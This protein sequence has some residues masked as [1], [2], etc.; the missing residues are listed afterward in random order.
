M[1]QEGITPR[2]AVEKGFTLRVD[3]IE[4]EL[5]GIGHVRRQKASEHHMQR[6]RPELPIPNN[7]R[8]HGLRG[9][10]VIRSEFK[11]Q[12]VYVPKLEGFR[13]A[14]FIGS[15]LVSTAHGRSLRQVGG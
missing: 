2:V 7:D 9:S 5:L 8:L 4:L 11:R 15:A 13:D 6:S 14:L 3:G 10:V 12:T 1:M